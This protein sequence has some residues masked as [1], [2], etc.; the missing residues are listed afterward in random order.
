MEC[1]EGEAKA[2]QAA[3]DRITENGERRA[4]APAGHRKTIHVQKGQELLHNDVNI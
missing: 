4:S 3:E 2:S 1:C